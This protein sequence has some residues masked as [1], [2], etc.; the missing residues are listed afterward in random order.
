MSGNNQ[1]AV[2]EN[3]GSALIRVAG[4]SFFE[5]SLRRKELGQEHSRQRKWQV[6][7]S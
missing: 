4:E 5:V 2:R 3:R 1:S 7:R 6:Q